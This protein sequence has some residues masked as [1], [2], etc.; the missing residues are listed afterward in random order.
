[1]EYYQQ[2][3]EKIFSKPAD[4]RDQFLKELKKEEMEYFERIEHLVRFVT[5]REDLL[6][7]YAY[8]QIKRILDDFHQDD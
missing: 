8:N 3:T 1:M 5:S 6:E 4:E 2:L 7:D